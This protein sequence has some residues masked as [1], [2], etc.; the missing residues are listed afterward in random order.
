LH[1]SDARRR[2]PYPMVKMLQCH[3]LSGASLVCRIRQLSEHHLRF[4]RLGGSSR[5]HP[6]STSTV[7]R[8][9]FPS[10][11]VFSATAVIPATVPGKYEE[12]MEVQDGVSTAIGGMVACWASE[13]RLRTRSAWPPASD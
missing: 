12:H 6:A 5:P 7:T 8:Q 4:F 2:M 11:V 9:I 3:G 13:W 10:V 1:A